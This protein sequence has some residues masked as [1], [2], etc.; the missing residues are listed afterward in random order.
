MPRPGGF[1]GRSEPMPAGLVRQHPPDIVECP[2]CEGTFFE[3]AK[4]AQY[5]KDH[6]IVPGQTPPVYG[7]EYVILR[8]IRCNELIEPTVQ[9]SPRDLATSQYGRLLEELEDPNWQGRKLPITGE[10]I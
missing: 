9:L 1:A 5:Q 6:H 8:C 7:M 2:N 3:L 10:N 4:L